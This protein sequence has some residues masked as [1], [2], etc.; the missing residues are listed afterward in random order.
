MSAAGG[1]RDG[2]TGVAEADDVGHVIPV[3][4]DKHPG[5]TVV[6]APPAGVGAEVCKLES[7][8]CKMAAAAG[9]RD[10]D[11]GSAEADNVCFPVVVHVCKHARIEVLAAPPA[12]I[13]AE[14]RK[15]ESG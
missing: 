5:I 9:E 14:V 12:R 11:P 2:D 4:V 3:H 13:G 10:K 1:K 6:A 7:G 15:L 8:L